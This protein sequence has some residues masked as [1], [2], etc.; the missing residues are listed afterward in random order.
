VEKQIS[1]NEYIFS[2]RLEIGYLNDRY[3]NLDLPEGDYHTLS[4]LIVTTTETIPEQGEEIVL[5]GHT[6]VLELVSDTKIET[7]RV[8]RAPKPE[9]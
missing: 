8:I 2:G 1:D 9:D 5:N 6:F 7:V 3:E 4:G